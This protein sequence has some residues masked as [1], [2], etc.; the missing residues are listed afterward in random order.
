MAFQVESDQVKSIPLSPTSTIA[1][2]RHQPAMTLYNAHS[3]DYTLMASFGI[4]IATIAVL[5]RFI[6][7][8]RVHQKYGPEDW[9]AV[10]S[11]VF[12]I[13]FCGCLIWGMKPSITTLSRSHLS[14]GGNHGSGYSFLVLPYPVTVK[15]LKV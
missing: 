4:P 14:T 15:F 9:F 6:A 10:V 12:F 1:I 3:R 7:R 2:P 5:L 11:L 8:A 13:G